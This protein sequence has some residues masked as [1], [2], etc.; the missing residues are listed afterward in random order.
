M[1]V[2]DMVRLQRIVPESTPSWVQLHPFPFPYRVRSYPFGERSENE[3]MTRSVQLFMRRSLPLWSLLAIFATGRP[4][5]APVQTIR[6]RPLFAFHG[7]F[8]INLHHFLYVTARARKGLDASR[9]AV[10]SALGDTAGFGALSPTDQSAWQS[11]VSYYES[12]LANRDILFDSTMVA[13]N[14][15]LARLDSS[16]KPLGSGLDPR[17]SAVLER[18]APIYR[19]VWWPRHNASDAQWVGVVRPLLAAYGDSLALQEARAFR[20]SWGAAPL[21]VDVTAYAN[22]AGA[23]TTTDPSR[24][25]ISSANGG[26]QGDQGLEILFHEALHTMDDSLAAALV[27]Q[28]RT[29]GKRIP[30]DVTHVFIFYTAGVLTQRAIPGHVPYAE[31]NGL[32]S[33]V[34]DFARALPVLRN[35]WQPYLEGKISFDEAIRRY[36]AEM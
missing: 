28:F 22:W 17:L 23:Y 1:A 30:H 7:N 9:D 18:V 26:N 12:T 25:T 36:V 20:A 5:L 27:A 29:Q 32:W 19:R 6:D 33:R 24:I 34:A 10:T 21:R 15:E 4:H 8:W 11:A 16:A 13:T 31:K 3:D 2:L 35:T 14:N